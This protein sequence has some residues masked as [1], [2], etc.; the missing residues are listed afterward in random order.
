MKN[1]QSQTG[2]GLFVLIGIL[3]TMI[4]TGCASPDT[5]RLVA[6][7]NKAPFYTVTVKF[8]GDDCPTEVEPPAQG[9][10]AVAA[11]DGVCVDPGKAVQWV[12]DPAGTPFEI[13]FD[14]F[15]GRPY[16]SHGADQKTSPLVIRRDSLP[17]VYKYS[18]FGV[19]CSGPDPV[20][21]PP[22]RVED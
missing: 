21:D 8:D 3:T 10:C 17:G 22:I 16:A 9:G 20:L 14:P 11:D 19:D 4:A 5:A 15:V 12:S 6:S 1:K 13:Y 7:T 18:V 2:R